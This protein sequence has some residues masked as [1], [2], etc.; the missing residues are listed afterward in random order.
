[1]SWWCGGQVRVG[2][3]GGGGG[4]D[5]DWRQ[6]PRLSTVTWVM[7][8]VVPAILSSLWDHGRWTRLCPPGSGPCDV[9][10]EPLEKRREDSERHL[11]PTYPI[12]ATLKARFCKAAVPLVW[13]CAGPNKSISGADI[14]V[15]AGARNLSRQ[16]ENR[17]CAEFG[18]KTR[19]TA[20]VAGCQ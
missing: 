11:A 17:V 7:S 5:A 12:S 15:R 1:M 16:R 8:R 19:H 3:G 4:P 9:C 13:G 10:T 14:L 6:P 20:V 2:R 18:P